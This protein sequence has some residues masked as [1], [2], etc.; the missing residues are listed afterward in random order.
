MSAKRGEKR[1]PRRAKS[2]N[3]NSVALNYLDDVKLPR[4]LHT[5]MRVGVVLGDRGGVLVEEAV[6]DEGRLPELAVDHVHPVL[7]PLV[8]H[9]AVEGEAPSHAEVAREVA[10]V[11][12]R[13]GD[14]EADPVRR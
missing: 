10:G 1:K 7:G 2:P 3:S 14:P 5:P 6:E 9:V 11:E 8:Q 13:G 12:C 4:M